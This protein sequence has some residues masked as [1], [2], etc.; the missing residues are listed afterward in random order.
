[1]EIIARGSAE[2]RGVEVDE[3]ELAQQK[4][5]LELMIEEQSTALYSAGRVW[6]DG[7]IH[8]GDSRGMLAMAL[9]VAHTAEGA[10]RHRLRRVE[11]LMFE[12]LLIANR[13]EIAIRIARTASRLGI[14]PVGVYSDAD[15]EAL[16]VTSMSL[17]YHLGG[18]APA[19][20]YLR[21]DRLLDV[22]A[23]AGIDAI[24]PGYGFLAENSAFAQSVVDAGITWIGPTP[25]QID[26]FGNK[27]AAKQAAIDAGVPTSASIT[28][29]PDGPNG[30]VTFPRTGQ[31]CGRRGRSRHAPGGVR[32]RVG[33]RR[34]RR[35]P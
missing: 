35:C 13:G 11:A 23:A 8:P 29:G 15:A 14:E 3:E 12:R 18:A 27:M 21:A 17:S 10:R 22:A 5:F 2:R 9:S 32:I 6:D 34:G 28:V 24:H 16:H 30:T 7:I 26:L 25:A 33:R 4:G 31:G 20:S 19:D 1:M